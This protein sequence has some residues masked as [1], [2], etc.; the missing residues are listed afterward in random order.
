MDPIENTHPVKPLSSRSTLI[1]IVAII[2]IQLLIALLSYPFLPN[3]VPTHWD[4]AGQINGYGSKWVD[5]FLFPAM[6]LGIY[7]LIRVLLSIGP[8]MGSE[9]G[10]QRANGEIVDRI[11]IGVFLVL[12]IVQLA[13]LA[14]SFHLPI[15][16]SFIMCLVLSAMILYIGNYLGKLRRNFWAGIRTPWTLLNDTVWERTH[17]FAGWLFVGTGAI[18]IV[19]SFVPA[20]RVWGVIGLLLLDTLLACVYSYVIYQRLEVRGQDSVSPPFDG[21]A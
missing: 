20:V 21:G 7:I 1:V 5:T 17:R 2:V 15:D 14:A 16:R 4:A 18:G 3:I 19:L 9:H 10:G 6:T 12:L 8:R 11:L 13:A